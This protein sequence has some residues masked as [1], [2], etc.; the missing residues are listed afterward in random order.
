MAQRATRIDRKPSGVLIKAAVLVAVVTSFAIRAGAADVEDVFTACLPAAI[1]P[2]PVKM[3]GS[4]TIFRDADGRAYEAADLF[5][6]ETGEGVDLAMPARETAAT[7]YPVGAANRWNIIPALFVRLSEKGPVLLQQ[8]LLQ[9]G[10]A[11]YVPK[12]L[13]KACAGKMRQAE[14]SAQR[15]AEG[16]WSD[17]MPPLLF[18]ASS[19]NMLLKA[20]GKYVIVRGRIVSLG[21]TRSTRYLNFGRYWKTD[22]TVTLASADADTV[23]SGL[24]QAGWS[25]EDLNERA[26]EIRGVIEV[27][28]GPLITWHH[29]EQLIVLEEKRAGRDGQNQN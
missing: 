27:R 29:P 26:V 2:V 23:L 17:G 12:H 7:A 22:F 9:A 3:T 25:F 16:I 4:D 24:A 1:T 5:L 14:T 20:A 11:I 28:D 18:A 19:P 13:D 10:Q 8:D 6:S 15:S 21:K